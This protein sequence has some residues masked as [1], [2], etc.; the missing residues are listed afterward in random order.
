MVVS[1]GISST[2]GWASSGSVPG[3]VSRKSSPAIA[4]VHHALTL[5]H[6]NPLLLVERPS[7][8]DDWANVNSIRLSITDLN[9][10]SIHE[11]VR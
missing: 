1:S 3:S 9:R 2:A 7:A 6:K 8:G 11:K 5:Q 10:T 4:G